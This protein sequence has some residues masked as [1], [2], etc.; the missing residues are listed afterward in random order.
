LQAAN[1]HQACKVQQV[2]NTPGACANA[3][4]PH[5]KESD[6]SLVAALLLPHESHSGIAAADSG[7]K[8]SQP[9]EAL[10]IPNPMSAR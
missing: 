5:G 3:R 9:L 1:H 7:S 2:W 4:H 8:P 6:D 10:Q